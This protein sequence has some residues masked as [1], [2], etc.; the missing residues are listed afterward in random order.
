MDL[1]SPTLLLRIAW[2]AYGAG[3]V[4]SLL[5][6]RRGRFVKLLGFGCATV[7]GYFGIGAGVLGLVSGSGDGRAAFEFWPSLIMA[8]TG[9]DELMKAVR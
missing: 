7:A 8:L 3:V 6:L 9:R 4:G 2:C 1:T 5:A